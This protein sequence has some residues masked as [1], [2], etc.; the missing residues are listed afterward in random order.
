LRAKS[1]AMMFKT[2]DIAMETTTGGGTGPWK[3]YR[4]ARDMAFL[5]IVIRS[6]NM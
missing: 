4:Q 3:M 6:I 2:D 5:W 1:G